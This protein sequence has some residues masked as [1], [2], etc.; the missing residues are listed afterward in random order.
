MRTKITFYEFD[1]FELD[2]GVISDRIEQAGLSP[3][4][5]RYLDW[6]SQK[7]SNKSS[8][9]FQI[10]PSSIR[11]RQF[12]GTICIGGKEIQILPKLLKG[13]DEGSGQ[14]L[15]NLISMLE[16]VNQLE[17]I[18]SGIHRLAQ[19]TGS[20]IEI[21]IRAFAN[22]L[23]KLIQRNT[24]RSYVTNSGNLDFV[25][26]RILFSENI[27]EN[28]TNQAKVF[29]EY[30]EF[31]EDNIF[32]QTFKYVAESLSKVTSVSDTK[33]ALVR[34]VA[35]LSDVRLRS[36]SFQE[37]RNVSVPDRSRELADTF[38]L[39]KM[40]LKYLSSDLYGGTSK[41]VAVLIDMNELFESFIFNVLNRNSEKLQINKVTF[42]KG[43]RLVSGVRE[44]GKSD[45]EPRSMFNTFQDIVV[46]FSTGRRLVIDTKY[47]LVGT[48][49]QP[50]FGI[51]GDDVYQILAY[52]E[53]SRT[54]DCDSSVSLFYPENREK[55]RL[56]FKINSENDV[57]F[58]AATL[59]IGYKMQ[60]NV[61]PLVEEIRGV[62]ESLGMLE[63]KGIAS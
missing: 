59:N 61:N 44:L 25:K 12:V 49:G 56:E 14:L 45:F 51:S 17:G 29:C 31:T 7:H 6:F 39:A 47:K 48:N 55:M 9:V 38:S 60:G 57:R 46:D 32:N 33:K 54:G 8:P 21:Y 62:F 2:E 24:P 19:H 41:S 42:Q 18:D 1:G 36:V 16:Y 26:G 52:R 53:I 58:S 43:R 20:F 50:H 4:E 15:Q 28:P 3:E 13:K 22:R 35:L 5:I 63:E 11:A 23:L 40:F 27:K 37:V 34:S 30:D 10:T